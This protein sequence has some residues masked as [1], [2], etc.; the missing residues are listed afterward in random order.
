MIGQVKGQNIRICYD[1]VTL[2][3]G[4]VAQGSGGGQNSCHAPHALVRDETA[5]LVYPLPLPHLLWLVVERQRDR[6]APRVTHHTARVSH[7][8][9]NQPSA[10]LYRNDRRGAGKGCLQ[11]EKEILLEI[12]QKTI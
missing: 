7:V 5:R 10:F 8:S 12:G 4:V 11:G 1:E 9:H 2:L 6:I 3:Q